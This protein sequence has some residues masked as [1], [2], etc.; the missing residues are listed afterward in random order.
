MA[1]SHAKVLLTAAKKACDVND[2]KDKFADLPDT[3]FEIDELIEKETAQSELKHSISARVLE[4][5]AEC[6]KKL[7]QL[8]TVIVQLE[9]T[10]QQKLEEMLLKEGQWV[11]KIKE[12]ISKI[13][14]KFSYFFKFMQYSG[15]VRLRTGVDE[16][17]LSTKDYD[18][19]GIEIL[20]KFREEETLHVLDSERQS[21]GERSVST[22]LYLM[23]LQ[24]FSIAPFRVVDE[25]NQGKCDS[26]C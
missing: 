4:D 14:T 16:T 5:H 3:L 22:I 13:N 6:E 2:Y 24:E 20:V 12:L 7:E 11:P 26:L 18:K 1:K 8:R 23:A 25:I 19:W 21:G 15:E 9:S 17:S 10:Y